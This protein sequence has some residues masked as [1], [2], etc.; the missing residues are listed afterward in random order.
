MRHII[1]RVGGRARKRRE[2][3]SEAGLMPAVTEETPRHDPRARNLV[4]V[5]AFIAL[6]AVFVLFSIHAP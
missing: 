2:E 6:S 4:L 1:V 5:T 3:E